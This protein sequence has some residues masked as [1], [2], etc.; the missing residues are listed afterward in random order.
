MV[1]SLSL[2]L[3]PSTSSTNL[4]IIMLSPLSVNDPK[5]TAPVNVPVVP[6]MLPVKVAPVPSVPDSNIL[7]VPLLAYTSPVRLPSISATKVSV[8]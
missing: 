8:V 2:L 1:V 3:M 6:L 4:V 5:F 7:L